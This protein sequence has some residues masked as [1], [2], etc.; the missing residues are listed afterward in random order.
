M[1]NANANIQSIFEGNHESKFIEKY[2]G[3]K[4]NVKFFD[5]KDIKIT[6]EHY[7]YETSIR[8]NP[9]FPTIP[10]FAGESYRFKVPDTDFMTGF[11]IS[12]TISSDE[13]NTGETSYNTSARLWSRINVYQYGKIIY[14]FDPTYVLSR[15]IDAPEAAENEYLTSLITS[16]PLNNNTVNYVLP[17]FGPFIDDVNEYLFLEFYKGLE[18]EAIWAGLDLAIVTAVD[19]NLLLYRM[20]TDQDYKNSVLKEIPRYN[21]QRPW[22]QTRTFK[23]EVVF[24]TTSTSIYI[25]N[26]MVAKNIYLL[27]MATDGQE[28]DITRVE[29]SI[30]SDMMFSENQT[31]NTLKKYYSPDRKVFWGFDG[32][33]ISV[34]F[35]LLME[36]FGFTGGLS[37][38]KGPFLLQVYYDLP[39]AGTRYLYTNVEYY[40]ELETNPDL[41]LFITHQVY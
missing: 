17:A 20:R 33:G 24:G 28:I 6:P 32:S 23:T 11:A 35:G 10:A 18:V 13:D 2:R 9:G 19:T 25:D 30:G 15:I 12:C 37:L 26:F 27:L 16:V 5:Y 38:V 4:Q 22:Y 36:R 31:S 7:I 40:T 34:P 1:L 3:E 29:L 21:F 41:G 8:A 14:S 39:G